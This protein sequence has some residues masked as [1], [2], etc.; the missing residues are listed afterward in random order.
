MGLH[1]LGEWIYSDKE[2]MVS[3]FIL[4]KWTHHIN[5][6][7]NVWYATFVYLVYL[8]LGRSG[9]LVPLADQA[10]QDAIGYVFMHPWPPI[11]PTKGSKQLI[12][13]T[14]AQGVV[15]VHQQLCMGHKW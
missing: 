13:P 6:L 15:F 12:P 1:P 4:Q 10:I 9:W 7:S 11:G 8:F 2:V 14:V 3:I 5:A